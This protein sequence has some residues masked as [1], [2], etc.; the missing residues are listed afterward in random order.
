MSINIFIVLLTILP[1]GLISGV[2]TSRAA[3]SDQQPDSP[4]QTSDLQ[5]KLQ[6]KPYVIAITGNS[7][8]TEND[9]LG[10]A[11]A[12]LQMFEQRGFRKADIDDAAFQMRSAYLQAGFA[13]AFVDY[14]YAKKDDFVQISF[15][16]KEGPRVF[17]E[18][19]Q[20]MGNSNVQQETLRGF[21]PETSRRWGRRQQQGVVFI[22]SEVRDAVNSIRDY[23]R[24][25]GFIDVNVKSP[26]L[27]FTDERTGVNITIEI[28]EGV[29]YFINQVVLSGDILP[30]LAAELEKIKGEFVG[31]T[32]YVRRK[33]MLRSSLEEA[34]DAIG[35]ADAGFE[36]N[37]QKLEE[38]GR[39][40][41]KAKITS[42]EIVRIAEIVISGNTSTRE[43]FI[44]H[45]L[46][47]NPGD[48]YTNAKR[49][50][51]F[52][53]LFDSGLFAKISI[54]LT[55]P[56]Q[57]SSRNLEVRVEEL[58]TRE[59]FVEP[60][61][62]SYER[63]RLR[64]G[65]FERNFLGTGRNWRIDGLISTKGETFTVSYTDPWFLDTD[66]RMNIPLFYE[67]REEPSYTS[68]ERGV[69]VMFSRKLSRNLM[70]STGYLYQA[71]QLFDLTEDAILPTEEDY[72]KGTVGVQAVWDTRDDIFY[73]AEGL[74]LFSGFDISLPALGSDLEFGRITLGC[75]YFIKLPQEYIIGL[76]ATSGLIIPIRDQDS[77]PISERFFNGGDTTVRSYK[78]SELGPKDDNNEPLGGLG[79]NVFSVELRKRFYRNFAATFYVDAGN[80]SPNRS[81]LENDFS[82]NSSRSELL[83]DTLNDFFSEFK[84]GIGVGLQ[85]LLPVGPIRVDVAYNPDPEE[86]WNEDSWV[87][88]FS[89]G[90]AF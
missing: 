62:G 32:Y 38:P 55:P 43:S 29:Q 35:F 48:I 46:Q 13:F 78:H 60:G 57:G 72:N 42:G 73:P 79:Y 10:A 17:I 87:F 58:P 28:E 59:V 75:R 76:R 70:V 68:E 6:N 90:M 21:F 33:L 14:N 61:W 40:N 86:R 19:I 65:I 80:V 12:E 52:R 69:S 49:R 64:A 56:E 67:R 4:G 7:H 18:E 34:Y 85:Y 36:L 5:D 81:L 15:V 30:E 9:L 77:I 25:E 84:F 47:F 50:M 71:T 39:V 11:A 89:L 88:H 8:F 37:M 3:L 82:S 1:A 63:L 22:E 66:I 83:D 51:S 44:R 27:D 16:I 23:Y 54:E 31:K 24:G 20:F 53:K 2:N 74:R 26:D 41:L 45:R